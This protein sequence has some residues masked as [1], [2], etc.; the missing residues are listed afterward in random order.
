[1]GLYSPSSPCVLF[2]AKYS[3]LL[4]LNRQTI[5]PTYSANQDGKA[6]LGVAL[7]W[8]DTKTKEKELQ[9]AKEKGTQELKAWSCAAKS[10]FLS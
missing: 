10:C 2:A 3:L 6:G 4:H 9:H 1:M 5:V 7:N 8:F